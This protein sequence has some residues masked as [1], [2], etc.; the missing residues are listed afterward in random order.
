M[1]IKNISK[2]VLAFCCAFLA[3]CTNHPAE[4]VSRIAPSHDGRFNGECDGRMGHQSGGFCIISMLQ[5]ISH[6]E[7]Y[8]GKYVILVGYLVEEDGT[9]ILYASES[10]FNQHDMPASVWVKDLSKQYFAEKPG[11]APPVPVRIGAR[12]NAKDEG[13]GGWRLGSLD[14][15]KFLNGWWKG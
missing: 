13:P 1:N 9:Y 14:D 12:F 7:R 3:G 5:L 6:P 8:D 2:V 15:I 4:S 10:S 11:I